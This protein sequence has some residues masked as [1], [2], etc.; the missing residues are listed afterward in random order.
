M[1]LSTTHRFIFVHVPKT[2]GTALT[3]ALE[4]Y[5]VTGTRTTLRRL[6]RRLPFREAPERAYFRKHETAAAIR[7]KMG[8]Q[9]FDR[10]MS[11]SV[12]RNPFDHAVSH[13]EYLKEF[14]NAQ[15]AAAFARMSFAEYLHYRTT[16]RGLFVPSFAVLPDQSRW[17]VDGQ[18]TVLVQRVLRFERLADDFAVLAS[19]LG[20]PALTMERINPTKAKTQTRSLSS[21]YDADTLATVRKLYA[22]DFDLFGYSRDLPAE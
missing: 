4:P 1:I 16:A 18:E 7:A 6:I 3:A 13:Y 9:A 17:L 5:G 8:A 2:A 22:R 12:V 10:L 19:D 14:R 20:L 21:Y 15:K 11:F